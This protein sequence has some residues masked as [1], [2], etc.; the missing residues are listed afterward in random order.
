MADEITEEQTTE[1]TSQVETSTEE[2]PAEEVT[3]ETAQETTEE[4]TEEGETL[5]HDD[6]LSALKKAR[7]DA[8]NYRTKLRDLEAQFKDAKTPDEV[9]AVIDKLNEDNAK[10]ATTLIRENVALK[11]GLPD[12]LAALISGSTREE[13]E[14]SAKVLAKY[15]PAN[16]DDPDLEGGLRPDNGPT[17][18]QDVREAVSRARRRGW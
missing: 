4:S 7:K 2:T 9:Q 13:M 10:E 8:G 11:H 16:E 3:E 1:E 14:A 12:D 6:A 5:S 15:A 17:E 18:T